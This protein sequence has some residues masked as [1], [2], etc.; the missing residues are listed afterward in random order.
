MNQRIASVVIGL[1]VVAALG[2]VFFLREPGSESEVIVGTEDPAGVEA[3]AAEVRDLRNSLDDAERRI[4]GLEAAVERPALDPVPRRSA[5][6]REVSATP[7]IGSST[8]TVGRS[9]AAAASRWLW[10]TT[11]RASLSASM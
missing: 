9:S 8:I 10:P 3:L 1:I 2:A 7:L 4:A 5:E 11:R 6:A